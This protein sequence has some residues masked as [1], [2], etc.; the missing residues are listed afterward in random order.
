MISNSFPM[1]QMDAIDP[2]IL[3]KGIIAYCGAGISISAPTCAPSWWTLTEEILES[4]FHSVPPE[5]KL[6]DDLII[7]EKLFSPEGIFEVFGNIFGQHFFKTFQA[8]D[9][10]EPNGNHRLIAQLAKKG[11]LKACFTT[12]FDIYIERALK[13]IGVPFQVIVKNDEFD[14]IFQIISNSGEL[15]CFYVFKIHGTIEQPE[16]II[17]LASAYKSSSGFSVNKGRVL[18]SLLKR[19]SCLFLGYSGWDF[20]HANYR[21]FWDNAGKEIKGIFWNRRPQE[22]GGPKFPLIFNSCAQKFIFTEADLPEGWVKALSSANIINQDDIGLSVLEQAS[23]ESKWQEVKSKRLEFFKVWAEE[24]P[25][26]TKIGT[27]ISEGVHFSAKF[28]E[29][30]D[31]TIAK[32]QGKVTQPSQDPTFQTKVQELTQ[33]MSKQ[34]ISPQDYQSQYQKLQL[35]S[36]MVNLDSSRKEQLKQVISNNQFPG[37]TDNPSRLFG[38]VQKITQLCNNFSM[39]EAIKIA[40]DLSN[41]EWQAMMKGGNNYIAEMT[42]TSWLA[43]NMTQDETQWK[44]NHEKMENVKAKFL[45]GEIENQEQ[46][47]QQIML[48]QQDQSLA[49]MGYD[50]PIYDW[51]QKLVN[52]MANCTTRDEFQLGAE[53]FNT[54]IIGIYARI[55]ADLFY[56][57]EYNALRTA[58]NSKPPSQGQ[59]MGDYA[60]I[61]KRQTEVIQQYQKGEISAQDYGQK[62]QAIQKEIT[63]KTVIPVSNTEPPVISEEI[64]KT[65]DDLIRSKFMPAFL[66]LKKLFPEPDSYPEMLMEM[67]ILALWIAGTQVIY[68]EKS[69]QYYPA[70]N[71]GEYL[72][73]ESHPSIVKFLYRHH[74]TWIDKALGEMSKRYGQTLCRFV[75]ELAEMGN[76]FSL[77][78]TATDLSIKYEE[79]KITEQNYMKIPIALATFY[80]NKG[81]EENALHYYTLGLESLRTQ[82]ITPYADVIVFRTAKLLMKTDKEKALKTILLG[83]PEFLGNHPPMKF[84]ARDLGINLAKDLCKELGYQDPQ[85]AIQKL[86]T[87]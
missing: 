45:S 7:K 8:L 33:K 48:I 41:R 11:I 55:N 16:T 60:E 86:F 20:E 38:F 53:A 14:E 67:A 44:P 18:E 51:I 73:I 34:E 59:F 2:L 78:K 63:E 57:P 81:D 70:A 15:P 30:R 61:Q 29:M 42:I 80:E 12:N 66:Q 31:Q 6:P 68:A 4:F 32:A 19:Y 85:E 56:S 83:Y 46:F 10:S 54:A 3:K 58:A 28:K 17:A 64:L 77:C 40:E 52:K 65:Y 5:F 43:A 62:L 71:R 82:F 69:Q 87:D 84:P 27:V 24:I 23:D 22:T 79:G 21:K 75:V 9:V 76:D 26:F 1:I 47:K 50:A 74:K 35:D 72:I 37:I 13:E 39:E 25:E 49:K 36:I